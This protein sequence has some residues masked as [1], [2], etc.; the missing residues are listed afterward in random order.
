MLRATAEVHVYIAF[1]VA[2]HKHALSA[3]VFF[4]LQ[5]LALDAG[6]CWDVEF[7]DFRR[8]QAIAG[9]FNDAVEDVFNEFGETLFLCHRWNAAKRDGL[10]PLQT[11]RPFLQLALA[12]IACAIA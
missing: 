10:F 5:I 7:H 11:P 1:G 8:L 4:P 3:V 12:C 6:I 2:A 9:I